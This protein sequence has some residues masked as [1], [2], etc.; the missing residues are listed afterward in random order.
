MQQLTGLVKRMTALAVAGIVGTATGGGVDLGRAVELAGPFPAQAAGAAFQET[1]C[2]TSGP[3]LVAAL[4][5]LKQVCPSPSDAVA[6]E[7]MAALEE[8]YWNKPVLCHVHA[9]PAHGSWKPIWWPQPR[10]DPLV[11][12]DVFEDPSALRAA[13]HAAARNRACRLR[14]N[15]LRPDLRQT[16]AADAMARLGALHGACQ[17]V[18]Y[19]E[20]NQRFE[21]WEREGDRPS[22]ESPF[23]RRRG[24]PSQAKSNPQ[25]EG[26]QTYWEER[27]TEAETL[28]NGTDWQHAA[29]QE[30][31]ELHHAWRMA[32]CRAVPE[33]ALA[34]LR[35][36]RPPSIYA[37][38][39][40]DQRDLLVVAAARLG[41]EWA[42][43]VG[44]SLNR[45]GSHGNVAVETWRD[46]PL[47][48]AYLHW[49]HHAGLA[50][51]LAARQIDLT[52]DAPR[53]DWRGW[54]RRLADAYGAHRVTAAVSRVETIL[55][56]G[57][58][59]CCARNLSNSPWP[60]SDL[61]TSVR[62][63]IVRRRVDE[64]GNVR[65]VYENGREEWVEDNVAYSAM[66]GGEIWITYHTRIGG[67][68]LR[69][70]IDDGTERWLDEW[71]N[72]HWVEPDGTE[73][74][75]EL[76]GTEWIL[77]PLEWPRDE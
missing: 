23:A 54:E 14:E 15:E 17:Y 16:C 51:L 24:T 43:A 8:R 1:P 69:R 26:W 72:E 63:E 59:P 18:R 53:F 48:L 25:L 31:A 66:P 39:P 62:T 74:W 65:W 29:L 61:P 36:L 32:K 50:Y 52:S 27:R 56:H 35:E 21:G 7:C 42:L 57:W 60:W 58:P 22:R 75:I 20:G 77:L 5:L 28:E 11:W 2:G 6:E 68:V 30:E 47:A 45:A 38:S 55:A 19:M 37:D 76:D 71:G 4:D 67:A 64:S 46:A 70:W 34:P 10:N 12:R 41:S 73:H 44:T 9:N 40:V 13:V 33:A 3:E 49:S